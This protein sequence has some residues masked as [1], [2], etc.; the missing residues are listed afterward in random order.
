M[1]A[2]SSDLN[3]DNERVDVRGDSR[4]ILYKRKGLKDPKWQA[5]IRVPNAT[6][7][8]IISTRT[9]S[10]REAERV[11]ID[12]FDNLSMRVKMGGTIKAK[13]F[14]QV[15]D[16]WEKLINLERPKAIPDGPWHATLER[17]RK[18]ALP[19]FGTHRMNEITATDFQK[20]WIWRK[21][22]YDKRQP[23]N[24]TLGR[25]RTA[26]LSLFKFACEIGHIAHIPIST[27]PKAKFQRRPT[28]TEHEWNAIQSSISSWVA[29]GATKS[30]YR[31]RFVARIYFLILV[32][33]G[34]RVGELR[35][36]RW[37]DLRPFKSNEGTFLVAQVTGKTGSREVVFEKRYGKLLNE[38]MDLRCKELEK[39]WPD[40]PNNWKPFRGDL[41]FCHPNGDAVRTFKRSFHS[42]L[43]FSKVPVVKDG[44]SRTIYSL[45]HLYATQRLYEDVSAFLLAKQMGTSVEMIEKFYGQT[46]NSTAAAQ[47]TKTRH[48]NNNAP[49][50]TVERFFE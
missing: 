28:F 10:L 5:R 26:I 44:L 38:L 23:A 32:A 41:V 24:S 39:T 18:Y 19:Y 9:A 42:L 6:G 49:D 17:V 12:I 36:L 35:R 37:G 14:R 46:M 21:E 34:V 30:T 43:A 1:S 31:D 16:E 47:I 40:E 27:A 25:E 13:T 8:Q 45:R 11:A 2:K 22:N 15:F 48:R 7:Y 20:F 33:T 3:D 4:I 50:Q 29:D